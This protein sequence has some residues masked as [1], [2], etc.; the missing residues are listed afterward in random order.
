MCLTI[1]GRNLKCLIQIKKKQMGLYEAGNVD[2]PNICIVAINPKEY[3]EKFKDRNINKKHKGV[4]RDTPGMTFES[5]AGRIVPLRYDSKKTEPKKIIR[6]R[7]QVKNTNMIMTNINKVK[8][9]R[10]NDKRY[11]F[12]DG[13]VSLPYGHPLLKEGLE[14]IKNLY[15]KYILLLRG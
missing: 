4:R 13:I 15:Q 12:S 3:F 5:Y 6:K 14:N 11:Y 7:L 9:A 10:L 1:F 8:F 2:N